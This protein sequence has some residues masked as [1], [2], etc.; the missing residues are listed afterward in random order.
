MCWTVT[1][2]LSQSGGLV[3]KGMRASHCSWAGKNWPPWVR[4]SRRGCRVWMLTTRPS[5]AVQL[6]RQ[7]QTSANWTTGGWLWNAAQLQHL[8]PLPQQHQGQYFRWRWVPWMSWIAARAV[9]LW[10]WS[11]TCT[12]GVSSFCLWRRF[13]TMLTR[14]PVNGFYMDTLSTRIDLKVSNT[15]MMHVC[16]FL[17]EDV[18]LLIVSRSESWLIRAPFGKVSFLMAW[19]IGVMSVANS[20]TKSLRLRASLQTTQ[21]SSILW[22]MMIMIMIW[23]DMMIWYD[24]FIIIKIIWLYYMIWYDMIW[25]DMMMIWYDTTW[26]E[27]RGMICDSDMWCDMTTWREVIA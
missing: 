24:H 21:A 10:K 14:R 20:M 7:L 8:H 16:F 13:R 1:V 23:C 27:T 18:D 19:V 17:T 2:S 15:W 25:Y 3:L 6:R 5:A 9:Q 4:C 22:I 12:A 26:F 11:A